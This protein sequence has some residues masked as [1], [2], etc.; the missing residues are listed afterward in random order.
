MAKIVG[1]FNDKTPH[2]GAGASA[3][4]RLGWMVGGT[5]AMLVSG[6]SIAAQPRWTFGWRDVVF[7]S[8]ALAAIVLR[9]L[10]VARFAGETA[11]GRPATRAHFIRYAAGLCIAAA[12]AWFSVQSLHL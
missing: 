10:D 12:L 7:W 4:V 1:N 2:R 8:A 11:D 5:L 3:L 9:Y 6:M